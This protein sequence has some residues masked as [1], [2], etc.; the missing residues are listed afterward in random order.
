[1]KIVYIGLTGRYTERRAGLF[2]ATKYNTNIYNKAFPIIDFKKENKWKNI[3][4]YC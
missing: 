1:M 4:T 2:S 3:N